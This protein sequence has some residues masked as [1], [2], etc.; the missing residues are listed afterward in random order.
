MSKVRTRFRLYSTIAGTYTFS[1]LTPFGTDT[2]SA[3]TY[4][5]YLLKNAK[6]VRYL[7][8]HH[9]KICTEFETIAAAEGV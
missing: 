1:F 2:L 3:Q 4:I 5:K 7:N 6:I 8:A 9:A